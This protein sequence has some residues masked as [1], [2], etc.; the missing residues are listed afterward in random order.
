[1][2][3]STWMPL[4]KTLRWAY[5]CIDSAHSTDSP[6]WMRCCITTIWIVDIEMLAQWARGFIYQHY[7]RWVNRVSKIKLIATYI[8]LHNMTGNDPIVGTWSPNLLQISTSYGLRCGGKRPTP[9][10]ETFYPFFGHIHWFCL[11]Y[12]Y[13]GSNNIPSLFSLHP[14]ILPRKEAPQALSIRTQSVLSF[15]VLAWLHDR[16]TL[17]F[18][19]SN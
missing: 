15:F 3:S 18:V 8:I 17:F 5:I 1:M 2:G 19:C 16:T 9:V 12:S 6:S 10:K 11:S 13:L 4:M 7:P 14:T